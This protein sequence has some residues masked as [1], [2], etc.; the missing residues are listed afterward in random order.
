MKAFPRI[1]KVF[2]LDQPVPKYY[3][4][5]EKL[6]KQI[7]Q[8]KYSENNLFPSDTELVKKFR[9]S[10]GTV[11]EAIK[12]LFQQGYLVREQGKGTFVTYKKIQQDPDRLIGFT[13]LMRQHNIRPTAR[14][15]EKKIIAAPAHIGHIMNLQSDEKVV[16]LVRLRFGDEQPLIIER[17][18]YSYDLFEPVYNM[19]L[20][21]NSIYEL[22][23]EFTDTRLGDANQRIEA[24]SAGQ[25]EQELLEIELGTPLLLI[26]RLINTENGDV[27][28]YSEDVY[29][30]DRINFY[31]KTVPYNK[32][33]DQ[34]TLPLELEDHNIF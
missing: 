33:I 24:I 26:K 31:T 14:I 23:Y 3:K 19:D 20:D 13:Q 28:Q 5:Y 9:V 30:S 12:L 2:R 17:S 6:L 21:N 11:R 34:Y 27:F 10:R 25:Q 16:R 8:G 18:F 4:I 29:R 32:E 7:R 1:K 15:I 22:L